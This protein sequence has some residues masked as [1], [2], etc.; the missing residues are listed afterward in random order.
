MIQIMPPLTLRRLLPALVLCG[1]LNP[2][3][4]TAPPVAV[5]SPGTGG[6]SSRVS[7]DGVA[8]PMRVPI[9]LPNAAHS[10]K[11][12]VFGDFGTGD[13]PQYVLAQ[14]M[15]DVHAA[16]PFDLVA[17]VGDNIYGADRPRDMVRK[18]ERPYAPLLGAGVPFYAALG[19]HD[20]PSQRFYGPFNMSG[21]LFYSVAAPKQDVRFFALDSSRLTGEQV[22]WLETEL[23]AAREGWK[24]VFL[25]HPLYSSGRRHGSDERLRRDLEPILVRFGV[26]VVFSGHDHF[27]ERTHPQQG[28][29][30]FVTGSG[31]K[32]RRGNARRGQAFSAL[33][34]D[35]AL[36][37]LAAEIDGDTMAFNAIDAKGQVVDSGRIRRTGAADAPAPGP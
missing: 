13:A 16:F 14:R 36:V 6:S 9:D 18:F 5:V 26:S 25:H 35:Q 1:L 29:T 3:C 19:N 22:R 12:A 24:I 34:A 33:V 10:L 2:A 31:G 8:A 11:F 15:A 20:S 4:R 21:R 7:G 30:Y 27:Y 32:L 28:V 17:L 37:F 23:A